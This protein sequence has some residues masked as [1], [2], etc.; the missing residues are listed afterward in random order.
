MLFIKS[1]CIKSSFYFSITCFFLALIYLFTSFK[2]LFWNLLYWATITHSDISR[3]QQR[4]CLPAGH[5]CQQ[6]LPISETIPLWMYLA[7][8]LH[9]GREVEKVSR[10][11]KQRAVKGDDMV[12]THLASRRHIF[13]LTQMFI[14]QS[15]LKQF[16]H[17]IPDRNICYKSKPGRET[18]S[19]KE[20][21]WVYRL[22]RT[23]DCWV[24]DL[25][26]DCDCGIVAGVLSLWL[27]CWQPL[28]THEAG[29][30]LWN[31]DDACVYAFHIGLT[32]LCR[33]KAT[34]VLVKSNKVLIVSS[35]GLKP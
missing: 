14:L 23:H 22:R 31:T 25:Y 21:F 35:A 27:P 18:G 15:C 2:I 24:A 3:L 9:S 30:D 7:S 10:G 13:Y 19:E 16:R 34:P 4:V 29:Y 1:L 6:L 20:I 8:G 5:I 12:H 11:G 26:L 17:C 28:T 32:L 33:F